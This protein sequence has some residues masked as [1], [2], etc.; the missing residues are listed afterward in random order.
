MLCPFCSRE[1]VD[2]SVFCAYCGKDVSAASV[3]VAAAVEVIPHEETQP[4][5][6]VA[7][8]SPKRRFPVKWC[9]AAVV[10]VAAVAA[11]VLNMSTLVGT[12]VKTFATDTEYYKYVELNTLKSG[13]DT[14]TGYYTLL[15]DAVCNNEKKQQGTVRPVLGE[16]LL[17]TLPEES[18]WEELNGVTLS[19]TANYKDNAWMLE[20]TAD[21]AETEGDPFRVV[22]IWDIVG[23]TL[24]VGLPDVNDSFLSWSPSDGEEGKDLTVPPRGTVGWNE[25]LQD[26]ALAEDLRAALPT[27]KELDKLLD[28]YLTTVLDKVTVTAAARTVLQVGGVQQECEKITVTVTEKQWVDI[29]LTVLNGA[30]KDS[31]I[32]AVLQE[33]Q[34]FFDKRDIADVDL[35][36]MYNQAV[37]QALK[38][39]QTAQI[40]ATDNTLFT[41]ISFVNTQ[42]EV[43]GRRVSVKGHEQFSYLTVQNGN[44]IATEWS[45]GNGMKFVGNG[46]RRGNLVSGEYT[47]LQNGTAL[48]TL[49]ATDF[50][51]VRAMEGY[52]NGTVRVIP[53]AT[54]FERL[55]LDADVLS[56]N[57]VALELVAKTSKSNHH[58]TLNVYQNDTL[59]LGLVLENKT[60]RAETVTFPENT[61]DAADQEAV[62]AWL[63]G[64]EGETLG[65]KLQGIGM[66]QPLWELLNTWFEKNGEETVTPQM[67]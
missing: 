6:T 51:I 29:A 14:L 45:V 40:S 27:G 31:E 17:E 24:F 9:I 13:T 67:H 47:L 50:D 43:I 33:A 21:E 52:M 49:Q 42:H 37:E 22:G 54:L 15:R 48:A 38:Q 26:T 56:T 20:L 44:A 25:W 5:E 53:T 12:V 46:T 41:L 16:A 39:V 23:E 7:A 35:P 36:A 55:Q 4:T 3:S 30:K 62:D 2:D 66:P 64:V 1:I 65:E 60:G 32:L 10:A 34:G 63:E 18:A 61:V 58:V 59:R 28:R 57:T 8:A 11:L 19:Y